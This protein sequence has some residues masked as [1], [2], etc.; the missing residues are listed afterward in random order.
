MKLA[1]WFDQRNPDGSKRGKE[2][3]AK[4]ISKTPGTITAYCDGRAWPGREAMEAIVRETGGEVTANDF[5][6]AEAT[7]E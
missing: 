7:A 4:A 3:F 2:T 6:R 1:D 5:L